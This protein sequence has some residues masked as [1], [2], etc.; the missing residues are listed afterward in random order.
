M[1]IKIN[2]TA[3]DNVLLPN[4]NQYLVNSYIHR[5]LGENNVYHNTPSNYSV[6]MIQ[7]GILNIA[8]KHIFVEKGMILYIVAS[9]FDEEFINKLYKGIMSNPIF[10]KNIKASIHYVPIEETMYSGYN[11]F[12]TLSPFLLKNNDI[13]IKVDDFDNLQEMGKFI[14]PLILKKLMKVSENNNL[15]LK[16]DNYDLNIEWA[17]SVKRFIKPNCSGTIANN[18]QFT[19]FS[20]KNVANLLYNIGIGQS[21]GSGF[22][23][24]YKIENYNY[25][26]SA[27]RNKKNSTNNENKLDCN[28]FSDAQTAIIV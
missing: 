21:T 13:P 7:G 8:N 22:G 5:C 18:C 23:C 27:N 6:S 20:N 19:L 3:T 14:K 28:H 15:N 26:R 11:V 9:S 1:R 25:Y 12:R 2:L 16:F 10:F 17:K 4:N 24:I